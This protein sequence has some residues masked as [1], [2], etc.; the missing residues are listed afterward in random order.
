MKEL[1]NKY[2]PCLSWAS[3]PEMKTGGPR[4]IWES[5]ESTENQT[6]RQTETNTS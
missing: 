4:K 6:D 3:S 2:L 5:G 1:F